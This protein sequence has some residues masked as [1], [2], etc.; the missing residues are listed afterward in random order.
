MKLLLPLPAVLV[1]YIIS[2]NETWVKPVYCCNQ[3]TTSGHHGKES[4]NAESKRGDKLVV[5]HQGS[6]R[7][8][9]KVSQKYII[10]SGA[11]THWCLL[12]V[13]LVCTRKPKLLRVHGLTTCL[14][15][16]SLSDLPPL[17]C[18]NYQQAPLLL[19]QY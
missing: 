10:C 15:L 4:P 1:G 7:I 19:C 8:L 5:Y 2:L 14:M 3:G 18:Q 13:M 11:P 17:A 12:L 9:T 16:T 6:R